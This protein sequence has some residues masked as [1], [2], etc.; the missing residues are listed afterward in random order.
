MNGEQ[1]TPPLSRRGIVVSALAMMAAALGLLLTACGGGSN[2]PPTFVR[3]DG[4][5]WRCVIENGNSYVNNSDRPSGR[6]PPPAMASGNP[7][8]GFTE[9]EQR[10]ID[11]CEAAGDW[12]WWE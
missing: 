12:D 10:W 3:D 4:S 1:R 8:R 11:E 7:F 6:T 9:R 2:V 5:Q